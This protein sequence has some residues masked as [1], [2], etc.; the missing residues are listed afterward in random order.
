MTS[1][2]TDNPFFLGSDLDSVENPSEETMIKVDHVSMI[3]NMA[4]ETL[5]NLKEYAIA[6]ARKEL[7]FKE[8]RALDN[9]SLEVK[10]GDVY[11]I[12]GSNGS[13]KST[14]LKIVAGVLDPTKG[15][16]D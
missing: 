12:L 2:N 10:K 6:L 13:G 8:F 1:T 7:R 9:V 5:N 15:T 3:F 16:C 14:L 4:S 11:G